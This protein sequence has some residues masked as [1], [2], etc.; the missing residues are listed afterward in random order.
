MWSCPLPTLTVLQS[1]LAGGR[2]AGREEYSGHDPWLRTIPEEER[3]SAPSSNWTQLGSREAP[4]VPSAASVQSPNQKTI[5]G[6]P[7]AVMC[8][9][10][11]AEIWRKVHTPKERGS[12]DEGS[13]TL[14]TL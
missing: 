9:A 6:L 10:G 3:K 7:A 11:E 8:I 12:R 4:L 2:G 13:L 5:S 14:Q 1:A